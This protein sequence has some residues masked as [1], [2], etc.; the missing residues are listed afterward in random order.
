MMN[1]KTLFSTKKRSVACWLVAILGTFFIVAAKNQPTSLQIVPAQHSQYKAVIFD[2]GGVLFTTST[3]AK[4]STIAPTILKNPTLLYYMIGLNIKQ[5]LFNLLDKVPAKTTESMYNEG[6]KLPQIMV[7]W[8]TGRP[9]NQVRLEV[10]R[11]IRKSRH[12]DSVKNLFRSISRL[13]FDPATFANSQTPIKPM[14]DLVKKL[15]KNGY[16]LYVLSNWDNESFTLLKKQHA[17]LFSQFEGI[18]IS[19]Q[20]NMG[21]PNPELYKR[22][23]EKYNLDCSQCAFVDDETNNTQAAEKLGI[24][25]IVCQNTSSVCKDMINLGIMALK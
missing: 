7:D 25:S 5:E 20:E 19:G 17:E 18:M 2:L 3:G 21:K 8:M 15:K 12:S 23:L 11:Q 13:M 10:L 1:F 9:S 4:V 16:K 14:V 6:K 24:N 22:L